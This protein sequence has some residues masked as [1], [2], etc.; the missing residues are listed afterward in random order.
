MRERVLFALILLVFG[1]FSVTMLSSVPYRQVGYM[2]HQR[3]A[4]GKPLVVADIGA[5]DELQH[6]NYVA[7][8]VKGGGIPV[9]KPGAKDL[10]ETYQ[11]HQPPLYYVL[12][13]GWSKMWG[14]DLEGTHDGPYLR[15]LNVVIGAF[16]LLLLFLAVRTGTD[17]SLLA[18]TA[19]TL[20]GL[21][22]MW[23]GLHS[24]IS[25]DPLLICLG[26][27]YLAA[28]AGAIRYGWTVGRVILIG[29]IL[30]LGLWTKTSALAFLI[31]SL[32]AAFA[33]MGSTDKPVMRWL[34]SLIGLVIIAPWWIRNVQVYGDPL[35]MNAFK[36]A[37]VGS[38]QRANLVAMIAGGDGSSFGAEWTYWTQWFGWWTARSFIG[39]FGQMDIF[40]DAKVYAVALVGVLAC[41]AGWAFSWRTCNENYQRPFRWLC[42]ASF[43]I[44]ALLFLQFNLT[45][46]QAQA[47]Y[48]YPAMGAIAAGLAMGYSY[49]T[50]RNFYAFVALFGVM[51]VANWISVEFVA[52]EF[53]RRIGQ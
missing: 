45:Y 27:A 11:S 52:Q 51:V 22:P 47:R 28:M 4:D 2:M 31:V 29:V 35:A 32:I 24:A 13:A 46:F 17:D 26:C 12:A 5:P 44:V 40:Y 7:T 36:A 10:Y 18:L 37:F 43:G 3:G 6:A 53:A 21:M 25:N 50:K 1:Y 23:I 8:L 20:C 48:L 19:V 9:L 39:V 16:S 33:K 34:P 14:M 42:V 41:V 30:G 38:A 15:G 49:L